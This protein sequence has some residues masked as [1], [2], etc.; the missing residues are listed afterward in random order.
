MLGRL[1]GHGARGRWLILG[2]LQKRFLAGFVLTKAAG[3]EHA[4]PSKDTHPLRSGHADRACC[5]VS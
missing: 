3:V 1:H 4:R 5:A 2:H